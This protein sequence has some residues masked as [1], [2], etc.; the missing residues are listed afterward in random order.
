MAGR[1]LAFKSCASCH[2]VA[3]HQP[4]HRLR[5]TGPAFKAVAN[6]KTTTAMGLHVFLVTPHSTMP[7]LILTEDERADVTA[8]ILSLRTRP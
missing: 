3:P 8:Y 1:A 4:L 6:A 2:V 7:N 5:A